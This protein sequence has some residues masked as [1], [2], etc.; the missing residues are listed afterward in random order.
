MKSCFTNAKLQTSICMRIPT[1]LVHNTCLWM[2]SISK[3]IRLL[4]LIVLPSLV[5]IHTGRAQ[6]TLFTED[7]ETAAIGQTPPAG[8]GIDLVSGTNMINFVSTGWFPT[9][10]PYSGSRMV[11]FQSYLISSS[12]SNRLKRTSP[13]STTG[14]PYVSVDFEWHA[15]SSFY[16]LTD[17]VDIQWSTNGTS[18]N[19]AGTVYR[20]AGSVFNAWE[21]E[22]LGLPA[23]AA[24]QANLYI[25]FLFT[26]D[27]GYNCHFDLV[28]IKGYTTAPASPTVNTTHA[29]AITT[30]SATLNGYVNANGNSTTGYFQYG[31]TAAYGTT[32]SFAG[33]VTGSSLTPESV[34]LI[35]LA[36]STTYHFRLVAF[37]AGGTTYGADSVFTTGSYPVPTVYTTAATSITSNSAYLNG[38][39]NANGTIT[40][41]SF[42]YGLTTSY[43]T[44]LTYGNV[45]G[46]TLTNVTKQATG[47]TPSTTYHFRC[48]GTNAYGT[49]YGNDT[50]FTTLPA[51]N[52]PTVI[53]T[54]ATSVTN[55]SAYLNGQVN[56]NGNSTTVTFQYGLT[57]S[58]GT[59]LTYGIVAGSTLTNVSKQA[60]GLSPS[61]TYHYRCVGTNINGTTYGNDTT[62]TTLPSGYPPDVI[63]NGATYI[64]TTT[65]RL[66][67]EVD[68]WG[69]PTTVT[70]EYGLTPS[71]GATVTYGSVS[72]DTMTLVYSDISGLS[73]VTLYHYRCVG[74]NAYGT[75]YGHDTIFTTSN[76]AFNPPTVMTT[77]AS[78][79]TSSHAVLGGIVNA[80]GSTTTTNFEYG[81]SSSYGYTVSAGNVT[82]TTNTP[83]A[84][85][86]SGLL[87]GTLYHF[88]VMGSNAGGTAYGADSTFFTNDTVPDVVTLTATNITSTGANLGGNFN[89]NGS[90]T[91]TSFEYGLSTSYGSTIAGTPNIVT[92]SYP[93]YAD[94]TLTGLQ[95]NTTYY[96]RAKGVNT[97][98]TGYGADMNFTTSS[99]S[100][101]TAMMTWSAAGPL[102]IQFHDI[103]TGG[104]TYR[105]WRFGDGYS[106]TQSDPLHTYGTA[107]IYSVTLY[108]QNSTT[109]CYDSTTQVITVND[110]TV[111][112]QSQ[113]SYVPDTSDPNTFN[114]IDQST[115][116][117]SHWLWNFGDDS[118]SVAQNPTHTFPGPGNYYVCL[119]IEGP[120]CI[121]TAC[122]EI[123]V[124]G[125]TNCTSYFTFTST[126]LSINF[127][128]HLYNGNP[129]TYSWAFGDG[130]TGTGQ[131]IL[132]TYAA[133]GA[134]YVTLNTVDSTGCSFTMGQTIL[135]GDSAQ[136]HQLYG[137]VYDG[138]FPLTTG[139]VTLFSVD[140][141]PPYMPLINLSYLDSNGVYYFAMVPNGDFY[142][143]AIPTLM[144]GYLPTYYGDVLNW[145]NAS[146]IHLGQPANP[147]NIHL[148]PAGSM[149][150]GNGNVY[151]Q[152]NGSGLKTTFLDKITMLLMDSN[153]TSI[154]FNPVTTGG[155][156]S[157]TSLDYG[158]YYMEAEIAG[159]HSDM[160]KV[161]LTP[162]NPN[163]NVTLTFS[164]N[165]ITGISNLPKGISSCIVYP[166]PVNEVVNISFKTI[167][168]MTLTFEIISMTGNVVLRTQK[169]LDPGINTISLPAGPLNSGVYILRIS[170]DEGFSLT[171][172]LVKLD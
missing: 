15:D 12:T 47:L 60:T 103:S 48:K 38:Q 18:W 94:A 152:I 8:W 131:T 65:A 98:G 115:G 61:T 76:P 37:N 101:C 159:V 90:V 57:T 137:Q 49:T 54:A 88:R 33:N 132:H 108:I 35:N 6:T 92:G 154:S 106:S 162:A 102:V 62:F 21:P 122:R 77:S 125:A 75:T 129:A 9:C 51:G 79:I 124:G 121:N 163:A 16:S 84:A 172:K 11:E 89:A 87:A 13:V 58:Y 169:T 96:Y 56:A 148:I 130:L 67:G 112:C 144:N 69:S 104:V 50:T 32:L 5:L 27:L 23:G 155:T 45:S 145:E 160:I 71:Y 91:A 107:G 86:V 2:K 140:T 120:G 72:G 100:G 17:R 1:G 105:H 20:A 82:G 10:T 143:Y 3:F 34:N 43:G 29:T 114:F 158:T 149:N 68:A 146:I 83:I 166:N 164:N 136:F 22:S 95:P 156:F 63:T 55:N 128:G 46:N 19:T 139:V 151:G 167:E 36:S 25:A 113:F 41:V 66:N 78:N 138:A 31:M 110:S 40:T 4:L 39:V 28:H 14:Y 24:N 165:R 70:F 85:T 171:R 157:F 134:Y 135:A 109:F 141:I 99:G 73:P 74:V 93:V 30:Y 59:T 168:P 117:I 52:A 42:Q 44:T 64:T 126:G 111:S 147:Y 7:F 97:F 133:A 116:N 53:T 161:I 127:L 142:I 26:S 118:S 80:N 81:T 170:S 153:G 123:S 150:N 119:A